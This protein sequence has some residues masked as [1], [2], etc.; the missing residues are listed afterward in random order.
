MV[1]QKKYQIIIISYDISPGNYSESLVINNEF[2]NDLALFSVF[3]FLNLHGLTIVSLLGLIMCLGF[4]V[5][6]V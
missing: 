6:N 1:N 5:V 3:S 2:F 4:H